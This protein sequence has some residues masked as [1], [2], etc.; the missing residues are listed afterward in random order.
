MEPRESCIFYSDWLETALAIEDPAKRSIFFEAVLKY[1]LTGEE[2]NT[3]ADVR[4][5]MT[6]V[7]KSIDRDREKYEQKIEKRREAGKK[8]TGNQYT[9]AKAKE[10][11][12]QMEQVSQNGTD[13][14]NG[15]DNVNVNDNDKIINFNNTP[16]PPK[17]EKDGVA[18]RFKDYLL[19]VKAVEVP[20][21][22]EQLKY[23]NQYVWRVADAVGAYKK[24]VEGLIAKGDLS[25]HIAAINGLYKP[26][27]PWDTFK[28]AKEMMSLDQKTQDA[29]IKELARSSK[30]QEIF[31]TLADK[32][33]YIKTGARIG[34]L[35]GF[36][37]SR[38]NK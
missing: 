6:I 20:R 12:E 1:A 19:R 25:Q 26:Q 2:I 37:K 22:I 4:L 15:N 17:G 24:V 33:K 18:Q 3:P 8:H 11:M 36:L 16:L 31:K 27:T 10:L 38:N 35:S 7:K 34:T 21:E 30:E 13:N 9:R 14:D 5:V 28:L 32:V 23:E 29:I